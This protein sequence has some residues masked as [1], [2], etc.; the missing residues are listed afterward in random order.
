M[1]KFLH[2]AFLVAS[3]ISLFNFQNVFA[4]EKRTDGKPG[5]E[6]ADFPSF[7]GNFS[8]GAHFGALLSTR[9]KSSSSFLLGADADYRPFALF[10]MRFSYFQGVQSPR[11]SIFSLAP[12]VHT[13]ISNFHP[14]LLGG[15]GVAIVT[16][17]DTKAKFLVS[18]GLGGDIELIEHFQLGMVWMY[19]AIFDSSDEHSISARISY[20]F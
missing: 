5:S 12:L 18:F 7:E 2:L 10:G 11:S 1:K 4:S 6:Y 15:P 3:S 13:K 19:H 9:S 14:Y 16:T 8:L 17:P 20:S